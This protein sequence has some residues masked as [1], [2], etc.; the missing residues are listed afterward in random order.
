M[1]AFPIA[2]RARVINEYSADGA[3]ALP[4]A[5]GDALAVISGTAH[6]GMTL[7]VPSKDLNGSRLTIID[8]TNAAHVVTI[9]AGVNGGSLATLTWDATG[10]AGVTLLAYNEIWYLESPSGTF[11]GMDVAFS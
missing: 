3:I 7:A 1:T 5:G 4:P 2:G 9:A 10:R 8:L 11:T 6:T